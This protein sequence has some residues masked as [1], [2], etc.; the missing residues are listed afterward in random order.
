[1]YAPAQNLNKVNI[2]F[3][4]RTRTGEYICFTNT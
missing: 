1:M 2:E 3:D 4:A